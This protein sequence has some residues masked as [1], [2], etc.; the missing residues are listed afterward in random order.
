MTT[1]SVREARPGA[2]GREGTDSAW[3]GGQWV[4]S[5]GSTAAS[6]VNVEGEECFPGT[7]DAQVWR[8]KKA[9]NGRTGQLST[10]AFLPVPQIQHKPR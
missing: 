5:Q 10:T 4:I 1:L 3:A 6:R 8:S 9:G 7:V 2:M